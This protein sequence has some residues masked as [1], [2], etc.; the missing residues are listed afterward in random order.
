M[1]VILYKTKH[2]ST[3]KIGE[4]INEYLG[5]CLLM[6]LDDVDL[7]VL[8]QSEMIII[9][10]PVYYRKL[11][12]DMVLFIKEHQELLI[13]KHYC[14][15]VIGVLTSEFMTF[16]TESFDYSILKNMQVISGLGGALYYPHLS[17]SEKMILQVMNSRTPFLSKQK[18]KDLFENFND[19]EIKMFVLKVKKVLNR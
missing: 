7:S 16:V 15:Y 19:N 3:R 8:R 10:A 13:S 6:S 14:L 12:K 18:N 1:K 4:L 11:D 9:G 17:I 2:G 5:D